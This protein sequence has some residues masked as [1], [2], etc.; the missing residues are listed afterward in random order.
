[1]KKG[2]WMLGTVLI[3]VVLLGMAYVRV[4]P[5]NPTHWH[6]PINAST[7]EDRV[8]GAVRVLAGDKAKLQALDT[9]AKELKRTRVL[10]GSV[11]QGRI[12]Y[13]TRSLVFGFP[14]LTT[15]ELA[16]GQIRMYAR[17]W[18][19]TSDMGVNRNRLERLIASVQGG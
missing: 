3:F 12:T 1:M 17:L 19:G 13:V 16:D 15:I 11:A 18:F 2:L 10:A 14:D 4:A 8:G 7:D 5:L 6:V 9:A